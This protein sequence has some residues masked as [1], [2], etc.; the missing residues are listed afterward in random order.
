M[1]YSNRTFFC[2]FFRW[3]ERLGV[4]GECGRITMPDR[5]AIVAFQKLSCANQNGWKECPAARALLDY[6]ER[7]GK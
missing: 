6:Y 2:P 5:K 4:H 1:G 7:T 3:D